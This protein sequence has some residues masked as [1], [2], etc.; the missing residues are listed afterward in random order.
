[1]GVLGL[2]VVWPTGDGQ[3]LALRRAQALRQHG[4]AP[5][6]RFRGRARQRQNQKLVVS[7]MGAARSRALPDCRVE[8]NPAAGGGGGS[9]AGTGAH[10]QQGV[11]PSTPA[12][13]GSLP[14]KVLGY[15]SVDVVQGDR[16]TDFQRQAQEILS[17]CER[18]G[19]SLVEFVHERE[20]QHQRPLDRPGL[21]YALGRIAAGEVNGLVVSELS[22]LTHSVPELGRLMEWFSRRHARFVA[23]DPGLDTGNEAG[24]LTM[25]T[26]IQVGRW[27]RQR[28]IERTRN[29]MRAARRSGPASVADNP[30][31][32]QQ[33]A[34]MRAAGMT[35]Q[36]IADCLN[37]EGVPTVRG[38]AKWRPSSVQ[39][40]AGYRRPSA[41]E[42]LEARPR[43]RS[44]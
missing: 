13:R 18:R 17:E 38:G 20:P 28:L 8:L 27:E 40:A 43:S 22:R 19:L 36:A 30:E 26:I 25:Q 37:R 15:A 14:V 7:G 31:L 42:S 35:L 23:V 1:V 32:R 11:S 29:G 12:S 44:G 39:A 3:I 9:Q 33:I 16:N 6:N 24:W 5:T 4:D 41:A 2:V 34:G 10:A 21:G